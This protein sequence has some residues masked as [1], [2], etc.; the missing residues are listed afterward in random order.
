MP[1]LGSALRGGS[2]LFGA[3]TTGAGLADALDHEARLMALTGAS[4]DHREAVAASVGKQRP[5]FQG[6]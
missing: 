5:R 6:R 3:T 2:Q 4:R 1:G